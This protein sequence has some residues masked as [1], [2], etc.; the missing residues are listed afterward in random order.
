MEVRTTAVIGAGVMGAGIAQ[1][2]AIHGY[3]V[4]LY[5][6]SDDI[7]AGAL[8]R[9]EH[10]RFGL[11]RAVERGKLAAEALPGVL[12]RIE[13]TTDFAA[14]CSGIDLAIEAVP[15]DLALKMRIFRRLDDEAPRHAILTSNTAGLSITALAYATLRPELVL[16]WHWSQ[17]ASIMRL[18]EL[19]VHPATSPDAL[20]TVTAVAAACGKNPIAVND[21]PLTWGFV[22]NRINAAVR[23]E[24]RRIVDEGVATEE[25][26]D[27]LMKDCFR[28]PMGPFEMLR[29]EGF[30]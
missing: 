30:N 9:I 28:W 19:I 18:A 29:G 20:A 15:E 14:A 16:G 17:P 26:V 2:L 27:Q 11:R 8:E 12:D 4:Q 7:L 5:D 13:A 22:V 1:A 24:S 10:H 23:H 3:R 25:Q 6:L 21:Q